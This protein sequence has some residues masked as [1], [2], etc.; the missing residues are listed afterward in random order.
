M[1]TVLRVGVIGNRD[2]LKRIEPWLA[3]ALQEFLPPR[4]FEI[5]NHDPF[6]PGQNNCEMTNHLKGGSTYDG[7]DALH[8]RAGTLTRVMMERNPEI[9][10]AIRTDGGAL[11]LK[12]PRP[13]GVH[14][15]GQYAVIGMLGTRLKGAGAIML[16]HSVFSQSFLGSGGLGHRQ[17][18][19][20]SQIA[21][22]AVLPR[23]W[24]EYSRG[25]HRVSE[26]EAA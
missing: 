9:D 1:D 17:E 5:T 6:P 25:V 19:S 21:V 23:W 15:D 8:F 14:F 11:N 26:S 24:N 4:R 7:A 20:M 13:N 18:T 10:I 16:Y 2:T 22:Q 3:K 12:V